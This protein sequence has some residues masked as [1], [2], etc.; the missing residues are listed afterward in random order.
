[1]GANEVR[2][3]WNRYSAKLY[4]FL[5]ICVSRVFLDIGYFNVIS[6]QYGYYGFHDYRS[7]TLII[8]SWI[9]LLISFVVVRKILLSHEDRNSALIVSV[10]FY[11]S[12]VPFTTCV[13]A[14]IFSSEYIVSNCIYWLI[15]VLAEK[16]SLSIPVKAFPRIKA[17]HYTFNDRIS[18]AIGLFSLLL[19]VFI[20][21]RY[22]N[23]RLN[24][25]LYSVY[26]LRIEARSYHFPTIV[27]YMFA[28]TKAITP[29]LFA[30]SVLKRKRGMA[31]LF[32]AAQ[33]LSF[34]VDGLKSTFFM[35]FL[36]LFIIYFCKQ[37]NS[38]QIKLIIG[39]SIL[40]IVL[41]AAIEYYLL[42]S[43]VILELIIRRLMFVPNY[44]SHCYYDFFSINV[45]DYFRSSFLR[46]F[47]FASPYRMNSEGITY[48]IGF[49][50]FGRTSMNANNG[51][52]ADAV[53]NFGKP[54][55]F[56]MPII[57]I[58][59]LRL[60]DRSTVGLDKRLSA[61]TALYLSNTIINTFLMPVLITHGMLI[62]MI[63][64]SMMGQSTS[65]AG[66]HDMITL[67]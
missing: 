39:I 41:I 21:G 40:L 30:Y 46:Y 15:L 7:S 14:G 52:I 5:I 23:F 29:V 28:W 26:D 22:T 58:Y 65:E 17:G 32:F 45:P 1:M 6:K 55:I 4:Y 13:A 9:I 16:L 56:I 11:V 44:L 67:N 47:G 66:N 33:M 12:F 49:Q 42:D 31:I 48:I 35:P 54:G 20:S 51:L 63:I 59:V 61:A 34:G 10:L 2:Q 36:V 8:T 53:T 64:L 27:S 57:L 38:Q 43:F 25:D 24:F 37:F 18:W 19:V 62:L 50:Y 60:F 3:E